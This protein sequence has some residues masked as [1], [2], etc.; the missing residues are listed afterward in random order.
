M[1][2]YRNH[3]YSLHTEAHCTSEDP[4]ENQDEDDGNQNNDSDDSTSGL[5]KA[6]SEFCFV[7]I[8]SYMYLAF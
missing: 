5:D 8:A 4:G 6:N 1:G 7:S 3:V 2:T